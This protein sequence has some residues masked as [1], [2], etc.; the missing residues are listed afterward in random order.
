MFTKEELDYIRNVLNGYI[1][2]ENDDHVN[3]SI[4]DK[5]DRANTEPKDNAIFS[6][7]SEMLRMCP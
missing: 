3:D 4:L 6:D 7:Y 2:N 1:Y 5:I